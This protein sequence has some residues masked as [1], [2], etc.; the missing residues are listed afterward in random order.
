[1]LGLLCSKILFSYV[2]HQLVAPRVVYSSERDRSQHVL[3][4]TVRDDLLLKQTL[5]R[6][7]TECQN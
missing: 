5:T 7:K 2:N 1:M 3:V 6:C 4:T